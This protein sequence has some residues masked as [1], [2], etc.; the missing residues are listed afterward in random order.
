[1]EHRLSDDR[2][3]LC[4]ADGA[5]GHT[6][7]MSRSTM[8]DAL[9]DHDSSSD[10]SMDSGSDT[11]VVN[12]ARPSPA[13]AARQDRFDLALR[14]ESGNNA[15][16]SHTAVRDAAIAHLRAELKRIEEG[17]TPLPDYYDY[18][19]VTSEGAVE[20]ENASQDGGEYADMHYGDVVYGSVDGS[21]GK[22]D[23]SHSQYNDEAAVSEYEDVDEDQAGAS[24]GVA[25]ARTASPTAPRPKRAH[26][27][28][29]AAKHPRGTQSGK[30][31]ATK[32]LKQKAAE[33]QR[34]EKAKEAKA[35]RKKE[36]KEAKQRKMVARRRS[37]QIKAARETR[38]HL[39]AIYGDGSST[40]E[41]VLRAQ[42]LAYKGDTRGSS[43]FSA[44]PFKIRPL[45]AVSA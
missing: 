19:H 15:S 6:G 40:Y 27:A 37:F 38:R 9:L 35:K 45:T 10:E 26:R 29:T 14:P 39:V 31:G 34:K 20:A 23:E 42:L 1:M 21:R 5:V 28:P 3:Y 16:I 7:A 18:D 13:V 12:T 24:V 44:T 17:G 4:N 11:A 2:C 43:G 22:N 36:K 33:K 8:S 25:T 32:K 41:S 30:R